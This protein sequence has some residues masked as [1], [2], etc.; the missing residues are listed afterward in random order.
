M[1]AE[2][3]RRDSTHRSGGQWRLLATPRVAFHDPLSWALRKNKNPYHQKL[4]FLFLSFQ[5]L[6]VFYFGVSIFEFSF[7][8]RA[9]KGLTQK[10]TLKKIQIPNF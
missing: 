5:I 9:Y 4:D 8:W 7:F 1:S 3:K 6:G 2:R 10:G